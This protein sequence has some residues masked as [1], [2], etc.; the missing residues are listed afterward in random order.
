VRQAQPFADTAGFRAI[1]AAVERGRLRDRSILYW[2]EYASLA[3]LR[4][5]V[6][7]HR[8]DEVYIVGKGPCIG[9]AEALGSDSLRYFAE[10]FTTLLAAHCVPGA[11]LLA[12][13]CQTTHL[14]PA[15]QRRGLA[16]VTFDSLRDSDAATFAEAYYDA[17]AAGYGSKLAY[18]EGV[19]ALAFTPSS[20]QARWFEPGR[21]DELAEPDDHT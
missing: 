4:R 6:L 10:A 18:D 14:G 12:M 13:S 20:S 21:G 19:R 17:R 7:N 5:L 1:L 16:A 9:F 11:T 2:L 3:D 15:A 8:C